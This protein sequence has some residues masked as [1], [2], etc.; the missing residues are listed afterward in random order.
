MDK[1][2]SLT[3]ALAVA[4]M[5]VPASVYIKKFAEINKPIQESVTFDPVACYECKSCSCRFSTSQG[6]AYILNRYDK[7]VCKVDYNEINRGVREGL[8]SMT[9]NMQIRDYKEFEDCAK[10]YSQHPSSFGRQ[11]YN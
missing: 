10:W 4:I 2:R 7:T 1:Y 6:G 9:V 8:S 11:A 5:F 3:L